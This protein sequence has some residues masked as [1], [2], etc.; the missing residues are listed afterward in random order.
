MSIMTRIK[1]ELAR[2]WV[3]AYIKIS[4]RLAGFPVFKTNRFIK[5]VNRD[6]KAMT[7]VPRRKRLEAYK[8][9]FLSSSLKRY[10][11]SENN[12]SDY[13]SDY[14]FEFV[15]PVNGYFS[16]WLTNRLIQRV[17]L[18]KYADLFPALLYY[19]IW[20]MGERFI[21]NFKTGEIEKEEEFF[22]QLKSFDRVVFTIA[23]MSSNTSYL[24]ESREGTVY[25]EGEAADYSRFLELLD[26]L[27][28]ETFLVTPFIETSPG[29]CKAI[30]YG[31]A[32][33]R[34]VAKTDADDQTT[35]M[36]C[37]L[38]VS[39]KKTGKNLSKKT[40]YNVD[41]ESGNVICDQ[42]LSHMDYCSVPWD[43][44][45]E[46]AREIANYISEAEF[47][48]VYIKPTSDSYVLEKLKKVTILPS[49][50]KKGTPLFDYFKELYDYKR[51][52]YKEGIIKKS[53]S[54]K[55][56]RLRRFTKRH[57]KKGIRPYMAGLYL[58]TIKDDFL[59]TKKPLRQKIWAW[60]RGFA[61]YRIDQY[62][63]NDDN[64]RDMLSDFDYAWL[65]RLN[66]YYRLLVDDKLSLRYTLEP[67]KE[68]LPDYYYLISKRRDEK[69]LKALPDLPTDY[70]AT[71][72]G[73]LGLLRDI[74]RLAFKPANGTH[75]DG[76]YKLEYTDGIY[77]VNGDE[78]SEEGLLEVL[79]SQKSIY[80][81]T[82]YVE[83]HPQ[84]KAIY[85]NSVNTIRVMVINRN[86][87]NPVIEHAY[88]RI[89][90]TKT[91][92]TDNIGYGG[93][94]CY[95]DKETGRY[96]NGQTIKDHVFSSCPVHPDTG[97][98][99]EG[100]VPNWDIVRKG[101]LDICKFIPQVEYLGFDIAITEDSFSIIEINIHQD[102]HKSVEYP[103][104]VK[105]Y[106]KKKIILKE[107]AYGLIPADENDSE[108]VQDTPESVL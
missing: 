36:A 28:H 18:Q 65:N 99:L 21:Y 52:A 43:E 80:C 95:M 106:Y 102:L 51:Y 108:T 70:P 54:R 90:S 66:N 46:K 42:P 74:K 53:S 17:I 14:D 82:E 20:I 3:V 81:I 41:I 30:G 56:K 60:K 88:M 31:D 58:N 45:C 83:M 33:Y 34:F 97:A 93:L 35:I 38:V 40:Y 61:S 94:C 55:E 72:D 107:K 105:D 11:L 73:I 86:L 87:A 75:G 85:P 8:H 37:D 25:I 26:S 15:N 84:L 1:R 77:Y 19:I 50:A 5:K 24:V 63:L 62:G 39:K 69:H 92:F 67:F 2:R 91:G 23:I 4:R 59:H 9:G 22:E 44:I 16:F 57:L 79:F 7:G 100:Y 78:V 10:N 98:V 89:G 49:N 12:Y 27:E 6:Y 76:F 101:I 71:R 13:I 103:D 47:V 68:Y 32:V 48:S 29:L 64:W 96:Y 104:S